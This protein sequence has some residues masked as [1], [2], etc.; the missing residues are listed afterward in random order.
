MMML[1][2]LNSANG[3]VSSG[4]PVSSSL[5]TTALP[6][7]FTHLYSTDNE[8]FAIPS[9]RS[10]NNKKS[11]RQQQNRRKKS[12]GVDQA[13]GEKKAY[14][15]QIEASILEKIEQIKQTEK[16]I[17]EERLEQKKRL[18]QQQRRYR[19]KMQAD[20]PDAGKVSVEFR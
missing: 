10:V 5:A 3:T 6:T 1:M 20:E 2:N 4:G 19:Q 9:T 16:S 14:S 7:I 12:T 18:R 11:L 17:L 13:A 15:S 8:N